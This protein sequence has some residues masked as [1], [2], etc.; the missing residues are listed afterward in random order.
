MDIYE[1]EFIKISYQFKS[2]TLVVDW[3]D[4]MINATGNEFV[5][6]ANLIA[7]NAKE[8]D[9]SGI[10]VNTPHTGQTLLSRYQ[11]WYDSVSNNCFKVGIEKIA[12][13]LETEELLSLKKMKKKHAGY[14]QFQVRYFESQEE[15]KKWLRR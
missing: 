13:I 3:Y 6:Q 8:Y 9:A 15:A 10:I 1:D 14:G 2:D 7:V 12:V 4:K 5:K 11:D